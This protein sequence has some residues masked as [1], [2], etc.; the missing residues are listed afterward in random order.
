[1]KE[2][3]AIVD[4]GLGNLYS[5]RQ[6]CAE[7]G[8]RGE[9]CSDKRELQRYS[10]LILPGV[11]SFAAAMKTLRALDLVDALKEFA[12][13]GKPFLG[14]CLGIQLLMDNSCEHGDNIGLGI[15]RG[16]TVALKP[17]LG[18]PMKIPHVGWNSLIA[19]QAG[20][21]DSYLEGIEDSAD[22]VYFVHSY[23]VVPSDDRVILSRTRYGGTDFCSSLQVGNI[24]A[25]QF[26][27]ERSGLPGLTV[28]KNLA[29]TMNDARCRL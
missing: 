10:G 21:Q 6:A 18:R 1:M 28:Y 25:C 17:Q 22:L 15:I 12:K 5:V 11:G 26:H 20:W 23:V 14:I 9:L 27:P 16:Q 3:V 4:Y 7:V 2:R 29:K 13:S 8:L 19:N 24:F